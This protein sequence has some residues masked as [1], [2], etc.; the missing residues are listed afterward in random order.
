MALLEQLWSDEQSQV[1][2]R[3]QK[4]ALPAYVVVE[5]PDNTGPGWNN[6]DHC[7]P[8]YPLE[9]TCSGAEYACITYAGATYAGIRTATCQR[10]SAR[11]CLLKLWYW[12]S[13]TENINPGPVLCQP[14]TRNYDRGD[15]VVECSNLETP[16]KHLRSPWF[17]AEKLEAV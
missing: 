4:G 9:R 11:G 13:A 10:T 16:S 5:F 1:D 15:S 8:V 6:V 14:V 3:S 12:T 2:A 17:A 7:V